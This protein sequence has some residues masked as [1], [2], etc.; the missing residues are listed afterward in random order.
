MKK[1]F[2]IFASILIITSCGIKQSENTNATDTTIVA[3]TTAQAD[4]LKKIA[5][6]D[7][8]KIATAKAD[9]LKADSIKK[10]AVKVKTVI[11]K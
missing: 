4:S 11:K 9:S 3:T 5:I 10:A 8:I 2:T 7:S 6:A 1:I